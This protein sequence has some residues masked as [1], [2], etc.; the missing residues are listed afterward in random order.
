MKGVGTIGERETRSESGDWFRIVTHGLAASE[1]VIRSRRKLDDKLNESPARRCSGGRWRLSFGE[2]RVNYLDFLSWPAAFVASRWHDEIYARVAYFS[3]RYYTIMRTIFSSFSFYDAFWCFTIFEAYVYL[4]SL[5]HVSKM[6][7][8]MLPD[9]K[10]SIKNSWYFFYFFSRNEACAHTDRI[11]GVLRVYIYTY[12]HKYTPKQ[13]SYRALSSWSTSCKVL[14][15]QCQYTWRGVVQIQEEVCSACSC[16]VIDKF[17]STNRNIPRLL[18]YGVGDRLLL[19]LDNLSLC[20]LSK[21]TLSGRGGGGEGVGDRIWFV[22]EANEWRNDNKKGVGMQDS[23]T[24][25]SYC[26]TIDENPR[27]GRIVPSLNVGL[28]ARTLSAASHVVQGISGVVS[29]R[30]ESLQKTCNPTHYFPF[31][32]LIISAIPSPDKIRVTRMYP[33]CTYTRLTRVNCSNRADRWV[34]T[35]AAG[36]W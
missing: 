23:R 33:P 14:K 12:T 16:S 5:S 13:V 30:C 36:S 22:K 18:L 1:S 24:R 27:R 11:R 6:Y 20:V 29:P 7:A 15:Y 35:L 8:S 2:T 34:T 32:P 21:C 3:W 25:V 4:F 31:L 26:P 17:Y 9:E 10:L 19:A 28:L